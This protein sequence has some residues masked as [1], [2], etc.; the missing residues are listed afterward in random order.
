MRTV[1][2][3]RIR[4]SLDEVAR[5]A[6]RVERWPDLLPHYRSVRVLETRGAER[7]VEMRARRGRIPVW[8]WARQE[9]ADQRHI[10]YTHV[11][12]ITRGME[13]EWRLTPED[14]GTVEVVVTHTLALRWPVVG[15]AIARWII[16]PLFVDPMARTTL[17]RI[18]EL[19][20]GARTGA[21]AGRG[22]DPEG[23]V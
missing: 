2:R 6:A 8:W 15:P 20:E 9:V 4:G 11:R 7:I 17:R 18:K 13:V 23:G 12:G 22:A 10:R 1:T 19:A 14:E 3:I 5:Y 21:G 16:G